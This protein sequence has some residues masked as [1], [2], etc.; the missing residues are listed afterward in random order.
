M[1][2]CWPAANSM[3]RS[4]SLKWVQTYWPIHARYLDTGRDVKIGSKIGLEWF[5]A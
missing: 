3:K 1:L 4:D 5:Q 2:D